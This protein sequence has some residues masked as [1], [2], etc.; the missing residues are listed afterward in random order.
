M[1][2]AVVQ[3]PIES[4]DPSLSLLRALGSL[5]TTKVRRQLVLDGCPELIEEST[6]FGWS[7]AR[8]LGGAQDSHCRRQAGA[9]QAAN[10]VE[11]RRDLGRLGRRD[12]DLLQCPAPVWSPVADGDPVRGGVRVPTRTVRET[13]RPLTARE[14]LDNPPARICGDLQKASRG[15]GRL[16]RGPAPGSARPAAP[17]PRRPS[18]SR[19]LSREGMRPCR[20]GRRDAAARRGG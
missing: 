7:T 11:W 15:S 4:L 12:V 13:S 9:R 18:G 5:K 10:A 19:L 6:H 20:R 14:S 16:R 17:R 8:L 1:D 2:P 3:V